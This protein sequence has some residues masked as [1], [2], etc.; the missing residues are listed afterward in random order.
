LGAKAYSRTFA[1]VSPAPAVHAG[2]QARAAGERFPQKVRPNPLAWLRYCRGVL[3]RLR[4]ERHGGEV[5]EWDTW[6][7]PRLDRGCPDRRGI[8]V[9]IPG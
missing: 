8:S 3:Q 9:A 1:A 5:W 7:V 4:D 2:R 6:P